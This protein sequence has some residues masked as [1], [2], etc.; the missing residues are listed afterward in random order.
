MSASDRPLLPLRA[1]L[2]RPLNAVLGLS[3]AIN[4]A[5]LAPSIYMLQVYDRVLVTRSIETLAMLATAALLTLV[6]MGAL[7]QL[8]SRMLGLTGHALER[9]FGP[10]VLARLLTASAR[11]EPGATGDGL[12]DL[13][14]L[15]AFIS[16]PAVV[17]LCDAPWAPVYLA[18]IAAFDLRLGGLALLAA[19]LLLGLSWAQ[20]RSLRSGLAQV[21]AQARATQRVAE[22]SLH[23]AEVVTA[24]GMGE[25]MATQWLR[26]LDAQQQAT[27]D[28]GRGASRL[29]SITR[30]LRQA[31]QIVML[32]A[33]AWLVIRGGATPGLMIACTVLLAR[34]L[35][36]VEQLMAQWRLLGD[37][38]AA[39]QRLDQLLRQPVEASASTAL[40]RPSGALSVEQLSCAVP[41]SPRPLLRQVNLSARPGEV[42]AVIGGSGAGKTTLARL[43][44]GVLRPAAGAVR[45]DG[46]DIRQWDPARLGPALG[47]LPQDV[48]LFAGTVAENIARFSAGPA[49]AVIAAAQAAQVHDFIVRLPQGYDTPVGERGSALSGGQRQRIALARALY[50]EPA[51][52]VLDE[53]DASL[54]GD[55]EDALVAAI[56][57]LKA[58]GATVVAVTQRRRLLSVADQVVVLKDGAV[59]RT[60]T[61]SEA[62]E[63]AAAK[64]PA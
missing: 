24:L 64:V 59:E 41:G 11:G 31:V 43:L 26:Q 52:V 5:L 53:P 46:A 2:A 12:R 47:Y 3:L 57:G 29:G 54:D 51:L 13:A 60:V 63:D 50:G 19:L 27:L 55:G 61:R 4:I 6:A 9:H 18:L 36:P 14:T 22:R 10:G 56:A 17:A 21:Q 42:V 25:S 1:F 45:L 38:R 15:R 40:P 48:E 8:R 62:G 30:T 49:E 20:D 33:G 32:G 28:G 44:V 23:N 39:Y 58:R 16:G 7:E 35:A 34:A 37:A